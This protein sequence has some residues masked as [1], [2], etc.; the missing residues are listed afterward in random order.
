M[1]PIV[2]SIWSPNRRR[3]ALAAV[4]LLFLGACGFQPL[5]GDRATATAGPGGAPAA[6]AQIDVAVI[7][8]REGQI[9]RGLLIE[10]LNPE[11][12]PAV[13]AYRL[14]VNLSVSDG[15]IGISRDNEIIRAESSGRASFELERLAGLVELEPGE[16]D[17]WPFRRTVRATSSFNIQDDEFSNIVAREGARDEVLQQLANDIRTQIAL[18]LRRAP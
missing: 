13:P 3:A 9:L 14:T 1:S 10:A 15:D 6:M 18:F 2:S 12:R 11:G 17:P 16:T 5:Y 8:D 4:G 7:A